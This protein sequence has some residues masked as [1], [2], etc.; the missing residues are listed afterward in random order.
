ME[1][2]GIKSVN[3]AINTSLGANSTQGLDQHNLGLAKNINTSRVLSQVHTNGRMFEQAVQNA[4]KAGATPGA[5]SDTV[6]LSNSKVDQ[7]A[8]TTTGNPLTLNQR[9]ARFI[10]EQAQATVTDATSHGETILK[11]VFK[12]NGINYTTMT[13]MSKD[14]IGMKGNLI[15][16]LML[17]GNEASANNATKGTITLGQSANLAEQKNLRQAVRTLASEAFRDVSE[18]ETTEGLVIHSEALKQVHPDDFAK[19]VY[20]RVFDHTGAFLAHE[21]QS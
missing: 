11:Q 15:D 18:I 4:N 13:T 19:Q 10:R 6:E 17:K 5:S 16:S 9:D 20:L 1:I 8:N 2:D 3:V 14:T 21:K 12:D 7:A